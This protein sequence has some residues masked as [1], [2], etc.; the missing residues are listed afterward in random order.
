MSG[1]ATRNHSRPGEKTVR[2][3]TFDSL[4]AAD[5]AVAK[6]LAAAFT[7]DEITV[8]CSDESRERYFRDFEHQQPAGEYAGTGAVAG[9]TIGAVTGGLAA[10]ALGASTGIVPLVVAG[11]TGIAAGSAAGTFVGT[12]ATRGAE[13]EVSN[14]YDQEVRAGRILVSA[15]AN[16]PD[17]PVRLVTAE[18]IIA[19]SG[20]KP[21]RLPE[22]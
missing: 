18:R 15:E 17:A 4:P 1:T 2:A 19:E 16:G 13:K 20:A 11:A 22:G 6:L 10:I 12:M 7:K 5:R 8:V 9:A 14:Y 21:V 3:G